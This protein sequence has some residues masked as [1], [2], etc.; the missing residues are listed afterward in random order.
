MCAILALAA[1][2]AAALYIQHRKHSGRPLAGYSAFEFSTARH[3]LAEINRA[4]TA[5]GTWRA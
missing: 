5:S 2:T 4:A 1:V 3:V